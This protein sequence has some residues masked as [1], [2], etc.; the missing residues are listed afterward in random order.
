MVFVTGRLYGH[1]AWAAHR[2]LRAGEGHTVDDAHVG[3]PS[4]SGIQGW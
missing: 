3:Q 1:N 4:T 2:W